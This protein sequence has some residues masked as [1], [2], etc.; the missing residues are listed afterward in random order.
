M[1]SYHDRLSKEKGNNCHYFART[2]VFL[3]S[4]YQAA[5]AAARLVECLC[6]QARQPVNLH[7][8]SPPVYQK[9]S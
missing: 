1:V 5:P 3:Y 7:H 2:T 8:A 9:V 6:S 4:L